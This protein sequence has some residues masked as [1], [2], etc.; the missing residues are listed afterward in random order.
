MQTKLAISLNRLRSAIYAYAQAAEAG[1]LT[2][3]ELVELIRAAD[4]LQDHPVP[5]MLP[6]IV[7]L[8]QH[9]ERLQTVPV[10]A[11][12]MEVLRATCNTVVQDI[13]RLVDDLL[14]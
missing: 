8:R 5:V 13:D 2:N 14:V 11:D 10:R 3:P 7:E 4:A 9:V 1:R 6:R 12:R